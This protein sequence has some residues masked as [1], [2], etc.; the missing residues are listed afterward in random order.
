MSAEYVKNESDIDLE[1]GDVQTCQN[2]IN[3]IVYCCGE[4]NWFENQ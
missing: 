2:I 4:N 3:E 1:N